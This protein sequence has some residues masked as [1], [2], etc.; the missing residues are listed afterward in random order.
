MHDTPDARR[1]VTVVAIDGRTEADLLALVESAPELARLE[2]LDQCCASGVSGLLDGRTVAI[3]NA[4]FLERLGIATEHL[5]DWPE[6]MR[7]HGQRVLF[8]AVDGRAVGFIGINDTT[9]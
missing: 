8:V 7:S 4:A 3:G 5:C 9:L 6:R 2:C 1:I